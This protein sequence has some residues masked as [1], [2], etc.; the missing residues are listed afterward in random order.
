MNN[1]EKAFKA[2]AALLRSGNID[3]ICLRSG[4]RKK[5]NTF[6]IAFFNDEYRIILPEVVFDAQ[7]LS[8]TER[9]LILHYLTTKESFSTKGEFVSFKNLPG[10]SFYNPTFR[11]RGP[12]RILKRFGYNIEEITAAAEKLSG[13]RAEYGDVSFR[14]TIFPKIEAV[15][16]LYRGDEEFPP[17]AGILFNDDIINHLPLEDIAVTAGLIAGRLE[18]AAGL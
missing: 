9:I 2:A 12:E 1:Y 14:L 8:L 4:A 3:E 11:K 13:S 18:K 17:E 6:S 7:A 16:V 10:A 5:G 15:I